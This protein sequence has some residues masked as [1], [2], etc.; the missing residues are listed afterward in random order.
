MAYIIIDTERC[1]GCRFCVAVCPVSIIR[2]ETSLNKGGYTPATI[3][4]K[5]SSECTGCSACATMCPEAAIAVY[6]RDS[7]GPAAPIRQP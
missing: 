6:R 4:P 2:M 1:K 7:N 3:D 5:K